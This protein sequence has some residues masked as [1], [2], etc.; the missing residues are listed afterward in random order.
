[1]SAGDSPE[2][3]L[4]AIQRELAALCHEWDGGVARPVSTRG[5]PFSCETLDIDMSG[6]VATATVRDCDHHRVVIDY[7]HLSQ[8]SPTFTRSS[9]S[10]G[11]PSHSGCREGVTPQVNRRRSIVEAAAVA[12][13]ARLTTSWLAKAV[14]P[15]RRDAHR[16]AGV[17]SEC[18]RHR[19]FDGHRIVLHI[20]RLI[21][22][23]QRDRWHRSAPRAVAFGARSPVLG[24]TVDGRAPLLRRI[25]FSNR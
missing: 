9:A 25:L 2:E 11:T 16:S 8:H 12:A 23:Y 5:D 17:L 4:T 15:A 18:D 19:T 14:V 6:R 13:S 22:I 24:Y 1:M 3:R 7:F 20:S 10:S 21:V